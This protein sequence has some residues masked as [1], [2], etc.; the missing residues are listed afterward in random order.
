MARL[1][2]SGD[3]P[4]RLRSRPNDQLISSSTAMMIAFALVF[5]SLLRAPETWTLRVDGI[6]RTAYVVEGQSDGPVVLAF[7]GHGGNGR[8]AARSWGMHELMP[9]AT[10]IYPDG[11]P[12]ATSRDLEGARPG[13]QL[14]SG[15]NGDRDLKFV[16]ALRDRIGK[17][18]PTLLVGH[19][20]GA[21]FAVL[22]W[23]TQ[24]SEFRGVAEIAGGGRLGTAGRTTPL[25]IVA[26]K[27]DEIVPFANQERFMN[28]VKAAIRVGEGETTGDLTKYVSADGTP[29]WT[30]VHG[31]GH[32]V[33]EACRKPI[34]EFF[35]MC[36]SRPMN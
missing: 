35:R 10:F 5:G 4:V 2:W 29:M 18:R 14:R 28:A 19:S 24:G 20:N 30:F 36:L 21:G 15:G 25:M 7:H 34:V 8:Q 32:P 12:T 9:E 27:Q 17:S 33:P 11:L 22:L 6:D 16:Q 26:G 13:W 31:G 23:A 3:G 1:R